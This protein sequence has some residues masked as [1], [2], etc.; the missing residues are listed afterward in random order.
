MSWIIGLALFGTAV[1]GTK[2]E[3]IRRG[4][5][6]AAKNA[7]GGDS[8]QQRRYSCALVELYQPLSN[9]SKEYVEQILE[10]DLILE[11][12]VKEVQETLYVHV[13][14]NK[15]KKETDHALEYISSIYQRLWDEMI[16]HDNL[17]LNCVVSGDVSHSGF[18][19]R[20][21]V[22]SI[23]ELQAVY[24]SN[25][26]SAQEHSQ[27]RRLSDPRLEF[28]EVKPFPLHADSST[29]ATVYY[30]DAQSELV[31]SYDK[32][33]LGGTFDRIHNGHKKL[34]TIAASVCTDCITI[35][36]TGKGMLAAKKGAHLISSFSMRK[37]GLQAFM[38]KLKPPQALNVVELVDPFGPTITDPSLQ[39]IV[40][41]S[42]TI[43]GALKINSLR[44]EKGMKPL[45]ILVT[46]R[47]ESSTLS[48]TFLR[49]RL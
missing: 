13:I 41:S 2:W 28:P 33:A 49:N 31:P 26:G 6:K 20:R 11:Q 34:L 25:R 39:A 21:E 19:S 17:Q 43:G 9:G 23:T 32:V 46:R 36:I 7:E 47:S 37:T 30:F 27:H 5:N 1:G 44:S 24:T 8:K 35:G 4:K 29:A 22:Y 15:N 16:L 10:N 42:E 38:S 12:A 14:A 45:D 3:S 48:S 40:V 18:R